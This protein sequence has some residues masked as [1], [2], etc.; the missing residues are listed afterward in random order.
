M[1]NLAVFPGTFDPVTLGHFDIFSR[2]SR[3]FSKLIIAVAESPKKGTLFSLEERVLMAEK[4][5]SC[6]PNIRVVG[7]KGMLID[8]LK[9]E[10]ADILVRGVR[11]VSDYDYEVQLSGMYRTLMPNIEIVMLPTSGH[12]AYIS[13]T[14][15]RDVIIHKGDISKFVPPEVKDFTEKK[16]Y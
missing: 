11:T 5:C 12:L 7:F 4:A 14:L 3:L 10:K 8:L 15:V 6:I 2:A 16:F 13:S 1:D 9:E